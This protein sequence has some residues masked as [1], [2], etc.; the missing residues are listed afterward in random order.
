MSKALYL[1]KGSTSSQRLCFL[2][3]TSYKDSTSFSLAAQSKK[4]SH[5]ID[6]SKLLFQALLQ[7]NQ[8]KSL[9][10]KM[11]FQKLLNYIMD[12]KPLHGI[13]KSTVILALCNKCLSLFCKKRFANFQPHHFIGGIEYFL[14]HFI[15]LEFELFDRKQ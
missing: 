3:K 9:V 6:G 7:K 11:P 10:Q 12:I 4:L 1:F 8:T 2:F 15:R 5:G 13:A 14:S